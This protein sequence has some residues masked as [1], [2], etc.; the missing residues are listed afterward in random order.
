MTATK[1]LHA[2]PHTNPKHQRGDRQRTEPSLA[3]RVNSM[4][5]VTAVHD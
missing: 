1:R 3:L 2:S 4:T 5:P